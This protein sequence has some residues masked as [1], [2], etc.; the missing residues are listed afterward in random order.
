MLKLGLFLCA[1]AL[2]MLVAPQRRTVA[3]SQFQF[4]PQVLRASV[5]DTLVWQNH[6]I[7]PHTA[8]ADDD[9]WDSGDIPAKGSRTMIVRQKGEQP[10]TCLYH[11]NMKGK[12]IVR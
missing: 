7:V 4:K 5:G 8:T 3:L 10:F 2:P 9:S 1:F 11:A 6:D 12:L